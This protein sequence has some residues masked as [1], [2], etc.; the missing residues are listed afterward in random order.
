MPGPM[1][2]ASDAIVPKTDIISVLAGR[3]IVK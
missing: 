1:L 2:T 3:Q